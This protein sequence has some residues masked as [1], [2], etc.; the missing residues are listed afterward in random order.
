MNLRDFNQ[1][2]GL[3]RPSI[4]GKSLDDEEQLANLRP[5]RRSVLLANSI[6]HHPQVL[7]QATCPVT[8]ETLCTPVGCNFSNAALRASS[9]L[10]AS[11]PSLDP[12]TAALSPVH[13]Y[14]T[15]VMKSKSTTH[16]LRPGPENNNDLRCTDQ[17]A[18]NLTIDH[19]P[20]KSITIPSSTSVITLDRGGGTVR[21]H[22]PAV[23]V[24]NVSLVYGHGKQ[25]V[26]VLKDLH[27][28][29]EVGCIY[30]L[31][32]SS[33]CGKT[34]LLKMILNQK[35]PTSGVVRIYG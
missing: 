34:S 11:L 26:E 24:Q 5:I 1:S 4:D 25:Q 32:G 3:R 28:Q 15:P 19:Y 35:R 30:A 21:L 18:N 23:D 12:L 17:N 16:L 6:G 9:P 33:G 13:A 22:P 10:T 8:A 29:V 2:T 14:R 7:N 27:M 31:L 20:L